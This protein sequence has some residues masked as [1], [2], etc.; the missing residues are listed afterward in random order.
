MSSYAVIFTSIKSE[1]L[2]GYSDMAEKMLNLAKNQ[3]GY[4][5]FKSFSNENGENVSISYW[6]TLADIKNWKENLDHQLAQKLGKA[7]WYKFYKLQVCKIEREYE[8]G[9]NTNI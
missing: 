4:I 7:K 2:D 8:F 9:I 3:K 5:D 6:E 1:K